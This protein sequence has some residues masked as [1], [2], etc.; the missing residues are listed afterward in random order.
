M[1]SSNNKNEGKDQ[2]L[3]FNKMMEERQQT[4]KEIEKLLKEL[5]CTSSEIKATI[6]IID[7]TYEKIQ[8]LKEML[9]GTNINNDPEKI[10]KETFAVI[11][12][13]IEKMNIDLKIKLKEIMANRAMR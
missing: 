3:D 7:S 12:G 4:K 5:K 11:S 1:S 2:K 6:K 13:L 9:I 10:E 8:A